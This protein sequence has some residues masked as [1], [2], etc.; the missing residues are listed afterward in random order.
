MERYQV[1]I[2]VTLWCEEDEQALF[3]QARITRDLRLKF[4]DADVLATTYASIPVKR[5]AA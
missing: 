3:H 5:V 2:T 1:S 4:P